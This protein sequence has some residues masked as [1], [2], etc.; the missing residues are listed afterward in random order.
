LVG[1]DE[2]VASASDLIGDS[3]VEEVGEINPVAPPGVGDCEGPSSCLGSISIWS[4]AGDVEGGLVDFRDSLYSE[5]FRAHRS[6]NR[7]LK[8]MKFRLR[9]GVAARALASSSS[10]SH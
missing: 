8:G 1:E 9:V 7:C 5:L 10:M 4:T 6:S 3:S 2:C